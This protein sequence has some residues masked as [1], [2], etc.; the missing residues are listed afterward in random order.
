[1]Y[2]FENSIKTKDGKIVMHSWETVMEKKRMGSF[3]WWRYIGNW[4][5]MGRI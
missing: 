1:M 4:F 3:K 2:L 5:Y